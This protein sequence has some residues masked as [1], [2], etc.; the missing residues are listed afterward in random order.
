MNCRSFRC[1]LFWELSNLEFG[2]MNN[3]GDEEV[4][5]NKINISDFID[6]DYCSPMAGVDQANVDPLTIFI[7]RF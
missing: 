7:R 4:T 5:H 3:R 6:C 1:R 2:P